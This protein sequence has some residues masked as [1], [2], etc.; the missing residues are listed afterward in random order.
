MS[1]TCLQALY[2]SILRCEFKAHK[3]SL[4]TYLPV[5]CVKVINEKV[6]EPSEEMK[7]V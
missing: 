6:G 3:F 5:I 1:L 7:A 4:E 2:A